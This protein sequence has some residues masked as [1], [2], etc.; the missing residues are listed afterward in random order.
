MRAMHLRPQI[1]EVNGKFYEEKMIHK[2]VRGELVRSK[3]EVIIANALHYNGLDYEYEP[4]LRLEDKVKR[5]DFK[6]EDYD[7]GVVWYWEHCGMMTDPQYK[8]R[9]EDKKKFYEKNGIVEG[10]NLIVT[11][12]DEKG[13]LDSDLI[14]KNTG[15]EFVYGL[16]ENAKVFSYYFIDYLDER[17]IKHD[18]N[19]CMKHFD[20]QDWNLNPHNSMKKIQPMNSNELLREL[21]YV[22]VTN[23]KTVDVLDNWNHDIRLEALI[24]DKIKEYVDYDEYR[25]LLSLTKT[26]ITINADNLAGDKKSNIKSVGIF[27]NKNVSDTL[28]EAGYIIFT[29][30]KSKIS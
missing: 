20:P 1:V 27:F 10:K 13:G 7:T 5:P 8:K 6:D 21:T 11:Y 16:I 4:E 19:E 2:T 24:L 28:R 17:K 3:S 9:W 30:D 15:V 14:Q 29:I 25:K 18:F 22:I 12:D 23:I 26:P